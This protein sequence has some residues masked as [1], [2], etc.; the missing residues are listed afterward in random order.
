VT[1]PHVI[2]HLTEDQLRIRR[3]EYIR[4]YG[5]EP[6]FM[7]FPMPGFWSV[8]LG[9][10]GSPEVGAAIIRRTR[11]SPDPAAPTNIQ[12]EANFLEAYL[13]GRLVSLDAVWLRRGRPIERSEYDFLVA[14]R[15]WA[16]RHAPHSAE[17]RPNEK[18]DLRAMPPVMPR[19]T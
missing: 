13:N 10:K 7:S 6:R 17:A 9:G 16:S 19:R 14:D 18:A 12:G 2:P 15:T 11:R 5:R 8:R 4:R 3:D 1:A